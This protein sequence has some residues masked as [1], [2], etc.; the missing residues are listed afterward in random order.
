MEVKVQRLHPK[1]SMPIQ[2]TGYST[3]FDLENWGGTLSIN[4]DLAAV[5]ESITRLERLTIETGI[6]V[7]MP[8]NIF[9]MVTLRSGFAKQNRV[10]MPN[11]IGIIDPD[12][13]G[14]LK[15]V[16]LSPR[17]PPDVCDG[18]GERFAQI[19][20]LPRLSVQLKEVQGLSETARGAGGFGSTGTSPC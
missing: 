12:Y 13:R 6:A 20:F 7:E 3:G 14:Q 15:V 19:V 4:Y 9:G 10:W 17:I 1:A 18:T 8:E 2:A 5:P 16:V 11:G